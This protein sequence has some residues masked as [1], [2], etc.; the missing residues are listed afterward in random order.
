MSSKIVTYDLLGD[1]KDYEALVEK[2]KEY[3]RWAK[4]TESCWFISTESSCVE[5]R[6]NLASVLDNDDRLFVAKLSGEAAWRNTI[7]K[8]LKEWL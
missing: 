2:I 6:D 1:G 7:S 8:K 5:V 3:S 4:I